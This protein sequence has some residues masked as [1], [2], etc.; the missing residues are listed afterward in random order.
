[1]HDESLRDLST[2]RRR[3]SGGE[4]PSNIIY[5]LVLRSPIRELP[6][7]I[8]KPI[9]LNNP[10]DLASFRIKDPY[11]WTSDDVVA[12]VLDIARRHNIPREEISVIEFGSYDGTSLTRLTE[13]D[14]KKINSAF[15]SL[16][17][18]EL[19]RSLNGNYINFY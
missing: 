7:A 9:P 19:R 18:V 14:F 3:R 15:G 2:R 5:L 16:M 12:W 11:K 8:N 1:M 13:Q 4:T 17:Y 10:I 6:A